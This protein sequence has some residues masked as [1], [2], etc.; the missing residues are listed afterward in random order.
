MVTDDDP[1]TRVAE[2]ER[3][4]AEQKH[5][6]SSEHRD[7][8][9]EISP[10]DVHNVAFS[11]SARGRGLYREKPGYNQY[12]VDR[13]LMRIEATLRDP[14]ERAVSLQRTFKVSRS[15]SRRPEVG[16]TTRTRSMRFLL[17]LRRN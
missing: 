8:R 17:A 3:D 11:E 13:Y 14:A 15:P 12:D 4:S 5:L 2:L 7:G 16:V 6:G 1:E 10:E 9:P